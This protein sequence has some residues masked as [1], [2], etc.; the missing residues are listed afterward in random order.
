MIYTVTL[1]PSLDYRIEID[2][3]MLGKTN[4]NQNEKIY[5]GGKGINVSQV[6]SAFGKETCAL[7]FVA[8]FTGDEIV[9]QL[10]ELHINTDF[11]RVSGLSCI[12]VKMKTDVETEMNGVGPI[13]SENDVACLLEKLDQL[14]NG[15]YLVLSGSV[16]I[17]G[18][19]DIYCRMMH[20]VN[21]KGVRVVVDCEGQVLLNTL[22]LHPFLIKPNTD[23]L[24]ALVN[25]KIESYEDA[26]RGART[27]QN[28][29]ARNVIVTL[30][31]SGAAFVSESGSLYIQKAV[32]GSV[33]STVGAGDSV[34]GGFV[35]HYKCGEKEAFLYGCASGSATCFVDGLCEISDVEKLLNRIEVTQWK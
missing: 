10:H 24:S 13:V 25:E 23:E 33:I 34:I 2:H 3:L 32:H 20:R 5:V 19:K 7:G 21:Q 4:R 27:L 18:G 30:G 14:Q 28:M 17:G 11:V 35:S 1:N 9:R 8:G 15:D 26:I 22:S 16:P 12:N 31:A 6:V 29:G